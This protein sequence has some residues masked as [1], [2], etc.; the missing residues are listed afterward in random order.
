M[1][2]VREG[3]HNRYPKTVFKIDYKFKFLPRKVFTTAV[4]MLVAVTGQERND[5]VFALE[6]KPKVTRQL[7]D[8]LYTLKG[9]VRV[10]SA[11]KKL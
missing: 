8:Q 3:L 2:A 5:A 1:E 4:A 9:A 11:C 7:K 10:Y 6:Y